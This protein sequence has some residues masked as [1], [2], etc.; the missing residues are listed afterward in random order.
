[1][2]AV[3]DYQMTVLLLSEINTSC[4]NLFDS[5]VKTLFRKYMQRGRT[6]YDQLAS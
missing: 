2:T 6:V 4:V 1:M 3:F 5:K